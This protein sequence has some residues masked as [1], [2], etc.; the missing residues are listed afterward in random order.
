MPKG[1]GSRIARKKTKAGE[2]QNN[3]DLKRF[4][5]KSPGGGE[6]SAARRKTQIGEPQNNGVLKRF[7]P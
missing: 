2:P 7:T 6:N 4:M 1:N 3:G 5:P